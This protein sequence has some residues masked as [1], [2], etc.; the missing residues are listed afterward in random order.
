LKFVWLKRLDLPWPQGRLA[1]TDNVGSPVIPTFWL[2]D[3]S[4]KIVSRAHNT[5][6]LATAI[7]SARAKPAGR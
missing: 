5:D 6:E 7:E 1:T 4:G 2:L 3:P